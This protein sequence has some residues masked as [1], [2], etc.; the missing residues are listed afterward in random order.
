MS[1]S[2]PPCEGKTRRQA[3]VLRK[4]LTGTQPYWQPSFEFL[5][6]RTVRNQ[7]KLFIIARAVAFDYRCPNGLTYL[8]PL[9]QNHPHLSL[10]QMVQWP[11]NLHPRPVP[12]S[13]VSF[14]CEYMHACVWQKE[15]YDV[16]YKYNL[17][18]KLTREKSVW[19][20]RFSYIQN[21]NVSNLSGL[22]KDSL[23]H[24]SLGFVLWPWW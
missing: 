2:L 20:T 4:A 12:S 21:V 14:P 7:F 3:A 23:S 8:F 9:I 13:Y 11:P 18:Y 17:C 24:F 19:I 22:R 5:A 10:L 1:L 16:E 15:W 6:S